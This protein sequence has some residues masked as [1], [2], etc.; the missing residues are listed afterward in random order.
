MKRTLKKLLRRWHWWTKWRRKPRERCDKLQIQI[1]HLDTEIM[2]LERGLARLV[3]C[4]MWLYFRCG[5][6][7]TEV[8]EELG[9]NAP[10]IRQWLARVR[11][12]DAGGQVRRPTGRPKKQNGLPTTGQAVN[13]QHIVRCAETQDVASGHS[14]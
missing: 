1:R 11:I 5:W 9:L 13:D 6:N 2:L 3:T 12:V 7:A 10:G 4:A 8:A 14:V